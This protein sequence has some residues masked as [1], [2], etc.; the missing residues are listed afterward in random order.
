M[1]TPNPWQVG[2][3]LTLGVI[4][5]STAAP[6]I[7]LA[8]DAAGIDVAG[9][10]GV[11]FMLAIGAM[12]L[13]LAAGVLLP[14]WS[15]IRQEPPSSPAWLYSIGAGLCLALHFATWITS[16]AYTSIAASTTLVTTN[17]IWVAL[18]SGLW[19][20]EKPTLRIAV[21]MGITVLG[22]MVITWGSDQATAIAPQPLLGNGLALVGS[23]MASLYFL[24]GRQA[25]RQGLSVSHY[26][27][28]A[29]STAAIALLPLPGLLGAGYGGYPL[30][31]YGYI[32][33]MAIV[34]Q[35]IGHTSLNWSLRWLSPTIVALVVL[36]EPIGSSLLGWWLLGEIPPLV[37]VWGGVVVLVGIAIAILGKPAV[38]KPGNL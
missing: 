6:L 1:K 31:V 37:V 9:H 15:S 38:A 32:F 20:G 35:L 22:S 2:G 27:T 11:G 34:S 36:F 29:Y 33:L 8:I 19:L 13:S 5:V 25:Q 10:S 14:Q 24:L 4:A 21:G 7:R 16:L 17:P 26:I 28:I 18:L 3:I 23:F 12:R 30:A